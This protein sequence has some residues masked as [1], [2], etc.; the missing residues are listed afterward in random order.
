MYQT[1][2][3]VYVFMLC[4]NGG[5]LIV[6]S[7]VNTP[8]NEPF[9]NSQIPGASTLKTYQPSFYNSSSNSGTFSGNLTT[10]AFNNTNNPFDPHNNAVINFLNYGLEAIQLMFQALT[11]FFI[12]QVFTA[13][14]LPAILVYVLSSIIGFFFVITLVFYLTGKGL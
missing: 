13:L 1:F 2:I 14:G 6:E 12:F 9:N 7:T 3:K 5:L 4:I 10:Q 11:P 8:L